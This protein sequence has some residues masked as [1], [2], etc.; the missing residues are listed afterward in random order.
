MI[1][2]TIHAQITVLF[3]LTNSYLDV[4]CSERF[5]H[6]LDTLCPCCT[7]IC[8]Y[9]NHGQRCF[10]GGFFDWFEIHALVSCCNIEMTTIQRPRI[11]GVHCSLTD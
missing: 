6:S 10:F 4:F 5:S 9:C 3:W 11:V 2:T 8:A 7:L 1:V